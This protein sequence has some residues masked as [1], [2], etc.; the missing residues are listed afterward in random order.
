MLVVC[1]EW[2]VAF[3]VWKQRA[4][5]HQSG[6]VDELF[7]TACMYY[8]K[9]QF[10]PDVSSPKARGYGGPYKQVGIAKTLCADRARGPYHAACILNPMH[11]V[12]YE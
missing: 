3:G 10:L 11:D 5:L 9:T 4:R 2:N 12:F 6:D 1:A 7:A 8:W